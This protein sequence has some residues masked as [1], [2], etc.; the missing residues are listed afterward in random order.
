MAL[1][2]WRHSHPDY[3][4]DPLDPVLSEHGVK[5]SIRAATEIKS[6]MENPKANFSLRIISSPL[7]RCLETAA[8]L[9]SLESK[10]ILTRT[11]L[12]LKDSWESSADFKE[13]LDLILLELKSVKESELVVLCSHSDVL[14]YFLNIF[15]GPRLEIK[16]GNFFWVVDGR[17]KEV[18]PL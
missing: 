2:F 15:G 8:E 11:E 7:K 5:E 14:E 9:A 16:K 10:K 4:S 18:N 3:G 17:V 12:R 6:R 1:C 13:R